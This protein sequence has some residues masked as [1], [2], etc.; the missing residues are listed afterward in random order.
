MN[1]NTPNP[2][3]NQTVSPPA[4]GVSQPQ[5][6]SVVS[7]PVPPQEQK[8]NTKMILMLI[9][10]LLIVLALVGGTYFYVSMQKTTPTES[11]SVQ[12]PS[13]NLET[14][15]NEVNIEDVENEF[16]TVDADLQKL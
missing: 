6:P 11:K 16:S 12:Q 4:A 3:P 5:P 8:S 15:L 1:P 7:T 10:G 13:D 2:M 14:E 9:G